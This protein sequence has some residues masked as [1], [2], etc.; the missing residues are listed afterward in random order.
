MVNPREKLTEADRSTQ[1]QL[2]RRPK[3]KKDRG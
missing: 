3:A 1:S 2:Q